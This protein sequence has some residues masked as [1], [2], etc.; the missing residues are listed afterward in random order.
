MKQSHWLLCVARN[1]DWSRKITPLLNL[2]PHCLFV[3]W[4]LTAKG[5]LSCEI[6]KSKRKCWKNQVRFCHHS[7]LVS[8]KAWMLP[9]ILQSWKN[10]LGNLAVAVDTRGHLIRVLNKTSVSADSNLSSL[11]L[12]ILK[13][14]W[15]DIGDTLW[16]QY[17]WPQAVVSYTFLAV[18]P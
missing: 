7:S 8:R 12:V 11:W 13:L 15:H 16:L 10:T 17:S 18:V 14:V 9:L 6:Y 2:T 3:E 5:E 4:K 1:C